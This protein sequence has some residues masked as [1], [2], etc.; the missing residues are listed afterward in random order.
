[1]KSCPKLN[2]WHSRNY[3][4]QDAKIPGINRHT[5]S[6]GT[7]VLLPPDDR[8]FAWKTA[9]WDPKPSSLRLLEPRFAWKLMGNQTHCLPQNRS[10]TALLYAIGKKHSEFQ[11]PFKIITIYDCRHYL[12]C[13]SHESRVQGKPFF[14]F[15]LALWASWQLSSSPKV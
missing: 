15:D 11:F 2:F 3:S 7:H 8:L 14:F 6:M 5:F 12:L 4:K 1:M 9:S 10:S 13:V